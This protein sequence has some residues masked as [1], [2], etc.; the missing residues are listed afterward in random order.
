MFIIKN[1]YYFYI[2]NTKDINLNSIKNN[3]KITIIY[4]NNNI[5][6]KI[7]SILR[8]RKMCAQKSFK[9]YVSNNLKLFKE[10]KADGM[11][12]SSYNKKIYMYQNIK[13]IGSA[14]TFKE[15]KQKL[16]QGC[17]TVFLSRL[18]KTSYNNKKD[19][20]GIVKCNLIANNY[21]AEIVPLGGIRNYNL[22]K[23]NMVNS[24]GFAI[25]SEVKK[26][27]AISNRLF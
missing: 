11:Y 10:S 25:L 17:K 1:N 13:L 14:H 6:E 16:A 22:N 9:F 15:I 12:L 3:K 7:D 20:L 27:P 18:F 24:N 26:K 19:F 8:F 21:N 4:R 5:P 2:E 23:L